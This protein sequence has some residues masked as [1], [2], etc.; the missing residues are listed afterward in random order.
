MTDY[1]YVAPLEDKITFTAKIK[2]VGTIT[3]TPKT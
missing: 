3:I 1:S 2:A